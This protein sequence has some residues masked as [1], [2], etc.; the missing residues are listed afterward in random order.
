MWASCKHS[1]QQ[2]F[3]KLFICWLE[4]AKYS[5]ELAFIISEL[6]L[7]MTKELCSLMSK[8]IPTPHS[9]HPICF[10]KRNN[11]NVLLMFRLVATR[12]RSSHVFVVWVTRTVEEASRVLPECLSF[13]SSTLSLEISSHFSKHCYLIVFQLSQMSGFSFL[14]LLWWRPLLKLEFLALK[15]STGESTFHTET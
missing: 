3:T 4:N 5:A 9:L 2:V 14:N 6:L 8:H 10:S 12:M 7:K 1:Q 11:T 13:A 15:L